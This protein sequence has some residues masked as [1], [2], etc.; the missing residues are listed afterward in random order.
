MRTF[1]PLYWPGLPALTLHD[2]TVFQPIPKMRR[3]INSYFRLL[4]MPL[5]RNARLRELGRF[6]RQDRSRRI[7]RAIGGIHA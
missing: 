6:L 7:G 5:W 4:G 2:G 1:R 3:S